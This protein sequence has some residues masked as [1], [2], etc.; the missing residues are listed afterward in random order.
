MNTPSLIAAIGVVDAS[1]E[2]KRNFTRTS[3]SLDQVHLVLINLL[4]WHDHVS[5][6]KN[7]ILSMGVVMY[8]SYFWLEAPSWQVPVLCWIAFVAFS[9]NVLV[10]G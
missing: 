2:L 7:P 3:D 10:G 6:W 9:W 1:K 5:L 8:L 4:L